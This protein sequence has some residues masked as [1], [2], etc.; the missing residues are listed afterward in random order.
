MADRV[1]DSVIFACTGNH[2]CMLLRL[3]GG[4]SHGNTDRTTGKHTDIVVIIPEAVDVGKGDLKMFRQRYYGVSL[5]RSGRHD[6]D[7][8]VHRSRDLKIR[9]GGKS[10]PKLFRRKINKD[11]RKV[12]RDET[13]KIRGERD[14]RCPDLLSYRSV[15]VQEE[16]HMRAVRTVVY[17]LFPIGDEVKPLG[18]ESRHDKLCRPVRETVL[19][20]RPI[21]GI[22]V[23]LG[24]IT[25]DDGKPDIQIFHEFSHDMK[26]PSGCDRK[27]GCGI[28]TGKDATGLI[29]DRPAG[30]EKGIID[31]TND[32]TF[33]TPY[34]PKKQANALISTQTIVA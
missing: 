32:Q 31:I 34:L 21:R 14:E 5:R 2:G 3:L 9:M 20:D 16:G 10:I 13:G 26:R 19:I 1:S 8:L 28:K 11:L 22:V 6:V 24:A 30:R 12:L 27:T 25:R 17:A 18:K 15:V 33:Q 23:D 29:R 7:D 4:I